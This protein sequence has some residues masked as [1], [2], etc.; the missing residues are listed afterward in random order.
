MTVAERILGWFSDVKTALDNANSKILSKGGT[1]TAS[2]L[3]GLADAIDS[4]PQETSGEVDANALGLNTYPGQV[5]KTFLFIGARGRVEEGTAE[6]N[7]SKRI[8]ITNENLVYG[9]SYFDYGIPNGFY[10]GSSVRLTPYKGTTTITPGGNPQTIAVGGKYCKEDIVVEA[11]ESGAEVVG[12]VVLSSAATTLTIPYDAS[13]G[14][15]GVLLA[16]QVDVSSPTN[17]G[18]FLV[19]RVLIDLNSATNC[20]VLGRL[21]S[22]DSNYSAY[23]DF[24]TLDTT[25]K[26]IALSGYADNKTLEFRGTYIIY[27]I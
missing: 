4:I 21:Y 5:P 7:A 1:S 24:G 15:N 20:L 11:S 22:G 23:G 9:S 10:M 26:T 8:H 2:D 18:R 6:W 14:G 19:R 27:Q 12:T 25:N 17:S 16:E 3:L 13:F